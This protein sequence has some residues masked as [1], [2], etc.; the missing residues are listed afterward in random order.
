MKR[1]ISSDTVARSFITS[2]KFDLFSDLFNQL[3]E[4]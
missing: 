4:F 2:F 3:F 1:S